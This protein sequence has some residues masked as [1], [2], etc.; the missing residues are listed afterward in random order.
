MYFE[1][2]TNGRADVVNFEEENWNYYKCD[3]KFQPYYECMAEE[4]SKIKSDLCPT[5]CKPIQYRGLLNQIPNS[6]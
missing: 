2:E 5:S 6:T 1:F 3:P 4:L